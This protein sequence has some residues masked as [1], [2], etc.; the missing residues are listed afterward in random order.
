MLAANVGQGLRLSSLTIKAK[1]IGLGIATIKE[2]VIEYMGD[3]SRLYGKANLLLPV[4]QSALET[5]FQLQ[6]GSSTTAR[7][8]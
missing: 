4:I 6:G 7:P 2:L 1:N 8:S 5:E 3:P